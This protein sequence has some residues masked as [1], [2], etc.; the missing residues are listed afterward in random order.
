MG[1]AL[2]ALAALPACTAGAVPPQPNRARVTARPP[3]GTTTAAAGQR[4]LG[5]DARD[6]MLRIPPNAGAAPLPLLVLLHGASS[7]GEIQLGRISAA[8]DAT[9]LAVLAPSS[10]GGTWDAI[11]GDFGVDPAFIDRALAKA[12]TLVNVDPRRIVL[13]GF[14]DGAT[15]ALSLGLINGDYFARIVAFSPGFVVDGEPHGRPPIYI[16]HGLSDPILPIDKCSRR[17]VP[18]L[19]A[20]GYDVTFREFDGVHEIAPAVATEALGWATR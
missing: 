2:A 18:A 10:R 8:C 19:T 9:G 14:S 7:S 6:A 17:I 12:F 13:G 16:S 20:R 15:Y 11:R 5:L 4:A 1:G 3:A